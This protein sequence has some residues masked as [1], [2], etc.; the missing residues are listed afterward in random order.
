MEV[1]LYVPSQVMISD[2]LFL[3]YFPIYRSKGKLFI[4]NL[5]F[6]SFS[7]ISIDVLENSY[8]YD[9]LDSGDKRDYVLA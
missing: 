7:S 9:L 8:R 1:S 3:K 4:R 6:D 5:T 2:R